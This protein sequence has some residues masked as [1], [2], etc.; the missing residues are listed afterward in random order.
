MEFPLLRVEIMKQKAVIHFMFMLTIIAL[1][2]SQQGHSASTIATFN[3]TY[4]HGFVQNVSAGVWDS[5]RSASEGSAFRGIIQVG[6][7]EDANELDLYAINRAFLPFN[8]TT[9]P[10]NANIISV[11]ITFNVTSISSGDNDTYNYLV[12]TGNTSQD[13]YTSLSSTD[14]AKCGPINSAKNMSNLLNLSTLV[15]GSN[16]TFQLNANGIGAI[17]KGGFS[18]FGIR[19]GHDMENQTISTNSSNTVIILLSPTINN[20]PVL[21]IEYNLSDITAPTFSGNT[22]NNSAPSINQAVQF[23]IS[24]EDETN[25]SS[26]IFSWDNGTGTFVNDT[27]VVLTGTKYNCSTNKTIQR[28]AGTTM[29]WKWYANDTTNNWNE[30]TAKSFIVQNT[31][32]TFTGNRTNNTSPLKYQTLQFNITLTDPDN[33]SG[34]IFSWSNGTNAYV[35]D[36]FRRYSGNIINASVNKTIERNTNVNISW[37]WYM[38]D[39]AGNWNVSSI[40]T[41]TVGSGLTTNL[42]TP[43]NETVFN[44]DSITVY[45]NVSNRG[46]AIDNCSLYYGKID[47]YKL[48]QEDHSINQ[49]INQSFILTGLT[50]GIYNWSVRCNAENDTVMVGNWTFISSISEG[51]SGGG[52]AG[53]STDSSVP[54][55][56]ITSIENATANVTYKTGFELIFDKILPN[57]K[58]NVKDN[59]ICEAG[60]DPLFVNR[61]DCLFPIFSFFKKDIY[62]QAWVTRFGILI[63]LAL[64]IGSRKIL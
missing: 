62:K 15:D 57:F 52:G 34:Y 43:S 26:C 39:S 42:Q 4:G 8:T 14:Y 10:A 11:N 3:V 19:E 48:I 33:L 36:S 32:S 9:L 2:S 27:A 56:I 54:Q 37:I 41:L 50:S 31:P 58:M 55:R 35:N 16:T 18:Y 47:T 53:G 30:S 38:N 7:S 21:I 28:V 46:D 44:S 49:S 64:L 59:G 51:S 13:S 24:W 60:E 61:E 20:T 6:T 63:A 45:Y 23:N 25:L 22:T 17:V 29:Q 1:I 5:T 12:V 40:Y